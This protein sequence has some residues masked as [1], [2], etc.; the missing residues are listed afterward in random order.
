MKIR[1][2][3]VSNSS[4]SSFLVGIDPVCVTFDDFIVHGL[5]S[6][7][8]GELDLLIDDDDYI[9]K[10][11]TYLDCIKQL[12]ED[13]LRLNHKADMNE[14]IDWINDGNIPECRFPF[15]DNK[16][17]DAYTISHNIYYVYEDLYGEKLALKI[18][19]KLR[20][21]GMNGIQLLER[22]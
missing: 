16:F 19:D 22:H 2:G 4:S 9:D 17:I 15:Y 6:Y 12:W 1:T 5:Y 18:Q 10:K 13:L 3:F 14:W 8:K 11:M 21:L 20:S 7:K